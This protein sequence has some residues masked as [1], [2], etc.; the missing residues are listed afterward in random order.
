LATLDTPP[1]HAPLH[2]PPKPA[3]NHPWRR[4]FQPMRQIP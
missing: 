3:P 4:P 2:L 1:P